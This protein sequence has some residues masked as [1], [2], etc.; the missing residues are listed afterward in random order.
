MSSS[1]SPPPRSSA[2]WGD[3][4]RRVAG[5]AAVGW[6]VAAIAG[7][8]TLAVAVVTA[9][10]PDGT[11][12]VQAGS[13]WLHNPGALYAGVA[14][15]IA[16]T[17]AFPHEVFVNPAPLAVLAAPF[18]LLPRPLDLVAWTAADTLCL[19]AAVLLI[20]R[21]LRLRGPLR[22]WYWAV[23]MLFPPVFDEVLASQ[24][25]GFVLLLACA[26]ITVTRRPL[27][28]GALAAGG[29]LIKLYP[30]FLVLG[31][32][33]NRLS[34][35]ITGAVVAAAAGLGFAFVR[36]GLMSPVSYLTKVLVSVLQ[37]APEQDCA[38]VS[39]PG[40][41][42][43]LLGGQSYTLLNGPAHLVS[44][45]LD[46]PVLATIAKAATAAAMIG[47]VVWAGWRSRWARP[48]APALALALG[49]V[50]PGD[51]YPYA[52]LALLPATLVVFVAAVR[53]RAWG[54]VAVIVA[55]IVAMLQQPCDLP[56]PNLWT[57]AMLALFVTAV[58][59]APRAAG[60]PSPAAAAGKAVT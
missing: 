54:F 10:R 14:E 6:T 60:A 22:A 57:L 40:L 42:D 15:T 59:Y 20:D 30:A 47:A 17:H 1:E 28:S 36:P 23:V 53:G 8:R 24:V 2:G 18:S 29:A 31:E 51:V 16:H 49:A 37:V 27:I 38:T 39:V 33:P 48:Y 7:M 25:T 21:C 55:S 44:A 35:F 9:S 56:V 41:W 43:R 11:M 34:R 50:I 5:T 58:A 19:L 4:F 52:V 13:D 3:A 26:A 32:G 12:F 46:I 45:V